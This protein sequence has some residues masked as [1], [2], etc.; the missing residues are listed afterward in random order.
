MFSQIA[1]IF[2]YILTKRISQKSSSIKDISHE[3]MEFVMVI[4]AMTFFQVPSNY[5][6]GILRR[7]CK[8]KT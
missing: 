1:Y 3:T 2:Q 7:I 8:C 5:R 6:V 4:V